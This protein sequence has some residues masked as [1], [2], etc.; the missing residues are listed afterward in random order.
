LTKQQEKKSLFT[1][2]KILLGLAIFFILVMA[3][4]KVYSS[5]Y[6][7]AAKSEINNLH[8]KIIQ[9][10]DGSSKDKGSSSGSSSSK[11][12]KSNDK[13]LSQSKTTTKTPIY[14]GAS[15][16]SESSGSGD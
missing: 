9:N 13:P 2:Y 10:A 3:S 5:I 8:G 14:S 7:P 12:S 15:G 11:S 1:P 4:Y 16:A 6:A